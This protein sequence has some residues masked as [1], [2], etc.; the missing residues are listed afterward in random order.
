MNRRTFLLAATVGAAGAQTRIRIG[1]LGVSHSHAWDKTVVVRESPDWELVGVVETDAALRARYEKAGIRILSEDELL[2]DSSIR[3]VAVESAVPDHAR[4][5]RRALAAGKHVHLEKPPADNLAEFQ[6]LVNLARTKGLLLQMGYMWRFH[7]GINAALEA[8]RKGWLGDVFLVRG[9]MNTL[10]GPDRRPEWALFRGGQMFEQG[11]HLIDPMV[12]LLGRPQQV[13]SVLKTHGRYD[14]KLADNTAAIFEFPRALGVI[15]SSVLHPGA[16]RHRAFEVFGTNGSAVVRPIE[17]AKLEIDLAE[18]AGPYRSG[19]QE[20]PLP[21]Y[22]RYVGEFDELARAI[23]TGGQLGVTPEEDLL[24]Q[25]T[26][27]WA[28]QM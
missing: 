12:R 10:I 17:P 22:R 18:S 14:D 23:R 16:A 25:E 15:T 4:D 6:D 9:T 26:L 5:A 19:L 21:P 7:P 24:V 13:T 3:V 1:F 8:A 28:S 20:V 11:C 27:L 2:G